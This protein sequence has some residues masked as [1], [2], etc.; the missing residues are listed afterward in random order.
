MSPSPLP[1][2]AAYLRARHGLIAREIN[3]THQLV[4]GRCT[5][6]IA[7]ELGL[8]VHTVRR[9]TER[10]LAKLAVHSRGAIAERIGM[11]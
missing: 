3:V 4:R 10:I 11:R 5:A 6:A 9:H 1:T 7:R 8:S 2:G